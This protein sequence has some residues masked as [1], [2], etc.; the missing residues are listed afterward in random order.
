MGAIGAE[1]VPKAVSLAT[2]MSRTIPVCFA[3]VFRPIK[4]IPLFFRWVEWLIPIKYAAMIISVTEFVG[5]EEGE[6]KWGGGEIDAELFLEARAAFWERQD[7][8][9]AGGRGTESAAEGG[10]VMAA[11]S[12][13]S[14]RLRR[15]L[16]AGTG[17]VGAVEI[18]GL[19]TQGV[20]N[21][22]MIWV[23]AICFRG[24]AVFILHRKVPGTR[25]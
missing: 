11:G 16:G 2:V 7:V 10:A 18:P 8:L 1:M 25:F 6:G 5:L 15:G 3:G 22:A 14:G 23:L 4:D 24:L 17:A 19:W 13:E 21:L 20:W 9:V 12:E